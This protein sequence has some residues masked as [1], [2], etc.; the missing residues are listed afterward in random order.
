MI[1]WRKSSRSEGSVN[2]A[3]I[4]V[5]RLDARFGVRDSKDPNGPKLTL[6]A[7]SFSELLTR[8]KSGEFDL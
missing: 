3:C 2:G 8:I 4:E 5:A 6:P 7:G 1:R